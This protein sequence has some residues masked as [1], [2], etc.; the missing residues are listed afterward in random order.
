[1]NKGE[2]KA[3]NNQLSQLK[4]YIVQLETSRSDIFYQNSRLRAYWRARDLIS[5]KNNNNTN[6]VGDLAFRCSNCF[7]VDNNNNDNGKDKNVDFNN[8]DYDKNFANISKND[9]NDGTSKIDESLS[10]LKLSISQET[11]NLLADEI[12]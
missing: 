6:K 5:N 2:V 10:V 12:S 11:C 3:V 7:H 4:D 9:R 8:S 1:M